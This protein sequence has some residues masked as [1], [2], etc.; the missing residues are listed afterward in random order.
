MAKQ[1]PQDQDETRYCER[2][3]IS[4][5]WAS[6]EQHQTHLSS[7]H[8]SSP[9]VGQLCPGC[10]QLLPA[11]GRERGLVRWYNRQKGYGFIT[12]A[13]QPELYVHRSA[14]RQGRLA[15]DVLVEFS[16]G[17]NQQGAIAEELIVLEES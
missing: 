2:C 7:P 3:G 4:F 8:L 6:E 14:V 9:T 5:L 16:L 10:R 12:R 1:P 13:N 15:P 11:L 17:V